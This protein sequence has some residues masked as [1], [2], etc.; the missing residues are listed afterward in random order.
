MKTL[1]AIILAVLCVV[2]SSTGLVAQV[3]PESSVDALRPPPM[4]FDEV[5]LGQ[6]IEDYEQSEIAFISPPGITEPFHRRRGAHSNLHGP[7][8]L[9]SLYSR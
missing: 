9:S 8:E 7:L 1:I 4:R 5:T 6:W 2:L 3:Y